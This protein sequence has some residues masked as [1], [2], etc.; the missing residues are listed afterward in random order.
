MT[1]EKMVMVTVPI[2]MPIPRVSCEDMIPPI[3]AEIISSVS[4]LASARPLV[5]NRVVV[6]GKAAPISGEL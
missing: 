5:L 6:S 2:S 3:T 1:V 4:E